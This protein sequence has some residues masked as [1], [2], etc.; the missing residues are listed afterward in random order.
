MLNAMSAICDLMTW[1]E[2][3]PSVKHPPQGKGAFG[4]FLEPL[5]SAVLRDNM[6]VYSDATAEGRG[7]HVET[8]T[9]VQVD[10]ENATARSQNARRITRLGKVETTNKAEIMHRCVTIAAAH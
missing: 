2:V 10:F 1:L 3:G 9:R 5:C 4:A 7:A 8:T 6:P